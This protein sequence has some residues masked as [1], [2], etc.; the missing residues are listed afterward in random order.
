M[1]RKNATAPTIVRKY[2]LFCTEPLTKST[3]TNEHVVPQWLLRQ[4]HVADK[5]IRPAGW[6]KGQVQ[7]RTPHSWLNLVVSD[8]CAGCNSGWLSDLENA[9]RVLLPKLASQ[10][11][12]LDGLSQEEQVLIARWAVKTAFLIHRTAAIP[13]VIPLEV[14]RELRVAPAEL[15]RRTFVFAFQDNGEHSIAINSLQTQD[16][17]VHVTYEDALDIR[18]SLRGACKISLRIDRLHLLVAYLGSTDLEPVGWTRVHHPLFPTR[19]R[20]WIDAGFQI[21]RVQPRQESSMV[22]FHVALGLARNCSQAQLA[23]KRPPDLEELHEE[24]FVKHKEIWV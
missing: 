23:G 11:R 15:P 5:M 9:V 8:V 19:C 24:F 21:H 3:S 14:Y 10:E 17:T 16:W 6:Q 7:L 18:D 12:R 2:C 20:L 4:F 1:N 22:L 13:K